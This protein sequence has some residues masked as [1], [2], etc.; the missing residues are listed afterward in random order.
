MS[1][2][3]TALGV[4]L[5]A[6]PTVTE[7]GSKPQRNMVLAWCVPQSSLLVLRDRMSAQQLLIAL[8][9]GQHA[10]TIAFESG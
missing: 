9:T 1:A 7:P 3:V 4:G 2:R 6:H 10:T 8:V 5:L